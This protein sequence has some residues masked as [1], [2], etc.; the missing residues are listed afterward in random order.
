MR[1]HRPRGWFDVAPGW[2]EAEC[3]DFVASI[4]AARSVSMWHASQFLIAEVDGLPP[5]RA[6]C[7]RAVPVRR[8]GAR[9][10]RSA[11]RGRSRRPSWTRSGSVVAIP[12]AG[13][14]RAAGAIG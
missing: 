3:L 13:G 7:L 4:A 11:L 8:R 5:R 12:E 10:R 14:F 6:R 1:G 2:H 9:S